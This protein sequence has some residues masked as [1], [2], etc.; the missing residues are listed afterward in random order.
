[1][2]QN[3]NPFDVDK[4]KKMIESARSMDDIT[5]KNG[6]IQEMLKG[7]IDRILHA[8]MEDHLGYSHGDKDGAQSTSNR[9]N[10]YSKKNIKTSTGK[11][12]IEVPRDREGS[13]NPTVVP[14]Y[15]SIDNK[16]QEQII[17]MYAK[18]MSTRDI[19]EHFKDLYGAD[20]SPSLISNVT[21][22]VLESAKEWQARPLDSVYPILFLDAIHFKVR[23]NAKIVTKAAY[24]CLGI[25]LEG[26]REVLGM[27]IGESESATF[28]LSVL[29]DLQN[30]GIE[31]ILIACV[32]GLKGF[33]EAIESIYPQTEVQGCIVHQIRNSLRYIS[34]KHRKE[35]MKDLKLVYKAATKEQAATKLD[36]LDEKWGDKYPIVIKSW[37]TNWEKLTAYFKYS[38]GIRKMIY[39]TNIIEGYHRQLRK[40]T[41]SK[42]IFPN[43]NSLFKMLYLAT[44]EASEKWTMSCWN[45]GQSIAQL[46]THFE[47]RIPFG[48]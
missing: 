37:R 30:R 38:E 39:T 42:T 48:L 45:W 36:E 31:D 26:K 17:S 23:D 40:V 16:T 4:V 12:Q 33:S 46:S 3:K 9:R 24:M 43:D 21:N 14:K 44:K 19:A 13:F 27:Y 34:F 1:M 2:E 18:G 41:K 5:G 47:G 8:E 20:V 11:V 28:W 15:E 25:T 10:G 22:K 7:T 29:T 32:D 35:F 6:I